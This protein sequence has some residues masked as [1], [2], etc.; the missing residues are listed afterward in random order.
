MES[1]KWNASW[2]EA[3]RSRSLCLVTWETIVSNRLTQIIKATGLPKEWCGT[4]RL[5]FF[6]YADAYNDEHGKAWPSLDQLILVCGCKSSVSKYIAELKKEGYLTQITKGRVGQRAE[7]AVHFPPK[8][9]QCVQPDGTSQIYQSNTD[10]EKFFSKL[11]EE[12][13]GNRTGSAKMEPKRINLKTYKTNTSFNDQKFAR[14]MEYLPSEVSSSL[15]PAPN[16]E[17]HLKNLELLGTPIE[18]TG[19]FLSS[20]DWGKAKDVGGY[21]VFH[22]R[23]FEEQERARTGVI[24]G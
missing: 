15:L 8:P 12:A 19:R 3:L 10:M 17:S 4:K 9:K 18:A 2:V 7:F 23:R 16:I 22:L 13:F 5:V 14:L 1:N 24:F 20:L 6:Y 21:F 11:R